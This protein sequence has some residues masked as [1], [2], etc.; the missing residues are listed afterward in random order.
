MTEVEFPHDDDDS[1]IEDWGPG[2][3]LGPAILLGL[4]ALVTAALFGRAAL[5]AGDASD[6]WQQALRQELK[7]SAAVVEDVRYVYGDEAPL[8]FDG[9]TLE[10]L[11]QEYRAK[12]QASRGA[13]RS[14]LTVE[15]RANEEL[16]DVV[17]GGSAILS[18]EKY[19]LEGGGYDLGRRLAD[20]RRENP[21]LVTINPDVPQARG[22]ALSRQATNTV[23]LGAVAPLAFLL[24]SLGQV[25][26][27]RRAVL[28]WIGWVVLGMTVVAA[29]AIEVTA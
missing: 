13:T 24:G 28:L 20:V 12:A 7:R 14:L 5:L 9:V 8:A 27:R 17:K 11:A 10:V 22:D 1:G 4:A 29:A 19:R 15:A 18:D 25:F 23:S 16:L 21:D 26:R 2:Q 3:G 6:Q